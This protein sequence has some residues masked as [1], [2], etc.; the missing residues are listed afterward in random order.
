M[1]R[2]KSTAERGHF[3]SIWWEANGTLI[4]INEERVKKEVLERKGPFRIFETE[5]MKS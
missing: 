2:M 3:K 1:A 4:V 5:S